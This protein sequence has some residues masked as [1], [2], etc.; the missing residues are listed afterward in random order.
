MDKDTADVG[1]TA[2]TWYQVGI[3]F[4]GGNEP[5][6]VPGT[7]AVLQMVITIIIETACDSALL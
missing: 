7:F 3:S 2:E 1:L 6:L 5:L 4:K